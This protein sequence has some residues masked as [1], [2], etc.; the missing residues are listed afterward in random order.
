M[1]I[2]YLLTNKINNKKYVGQTSRPLNLRINEHKKKKSNRKS[3]ICLAIQ[4]YGFENFNVEE[5][6]SCKTRD[7]ANFLEI[8]LI[9]QLNTTNRYIGYNA[10]D[11]GD[12]PIVDS[13]SENHRRLNISKALMGKKMSLE[14]RQ[15]MSKAKKG[16]P[17]PRKGLKASDKTRKKLSDS[18]KGQIPG[19]CRPIGAFKN[20]QL[21]LSYPNMTIC[22]KD[23]FYHQMIRKCITGKFK[24]Y[25]GYTWQYLEVSK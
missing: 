15:N 13:I 23:G 7:D 2:I 3:R 17:S 1:Y 19:N 11:G 24:Q 8:L 4:K 18:H 12:G 21:M 14:T 9:K 10:T 22:A 20:G 5:L 25:K 6:C 16:K